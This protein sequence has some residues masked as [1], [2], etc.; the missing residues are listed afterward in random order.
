MGRNSFARSVF[1]RAPDLRFVLTRSHT[2]DH[3]LAGEIE[4]LEPGARGAYYTGNGIVLVVERYAHNY[5]ERRDVSEELA[6][7]THIGPKAFEVV[8]VT[9]PRV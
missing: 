9:G 1:Q 2:Q 3:G 4:A 5:L 7:F 8:A 6:H